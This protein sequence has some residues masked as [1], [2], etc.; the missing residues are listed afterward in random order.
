MLFPKGPTQRAAPEIFQDEGWE[1]WSRTRGLRTHTP[2]SLLPRSNGL[3]CLLHVEK[4]PGAKLL[5]L[6]YREAIASHEFGDMTF[7]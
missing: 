5:C 7:T 2:Q 6:R 3:D 1:E 4:A